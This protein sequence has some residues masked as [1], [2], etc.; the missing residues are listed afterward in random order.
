MALEQWSGLAGPFAIE[1]SPTPQ[2]TGTAIKATFAEHVG[3]PQADP[4]D[5]PAPYTSVQMG[6]VKEILNWE[7]DQS[8][9]HP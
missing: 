8:P 3:V 7:P 9:G 1:S 4:Q 6:D 5:P 2:G